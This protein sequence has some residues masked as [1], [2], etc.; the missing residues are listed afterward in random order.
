MV[1]RKLQYNESYLFFSLFCPKAPTLQVQPALAFASAVLDASDA[2]LLKLDQ[3][4]HPQRFFQTLTQA[5]EQ[6]F[7]QSF[8]M[9]AFSPLKLFCV[10]L[11]H[12]PVNFWSWCMQVSH[13]AKPLERLV[14]QFVCISVYHKRHL[15]FCPPV[16]VKRFPD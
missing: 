8:P 7:P 13:H 6:S 3:M 15:K 1:S 5:G 16:T 9:N 11:C 10:F 2:R 12:Q 14:S 4:S